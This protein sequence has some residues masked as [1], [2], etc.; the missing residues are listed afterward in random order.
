VKAH[1]QIRVQVGVNQHGR[2]QIR[3]VIAVGVERATAVVCSELVVQ[4]HLRRPQNRAYVTV[5]AHPQV[6]VDVRVDEHRS[7]QVNEISILGG[8]IPSGPSSVH[9]RSRLSPNDGR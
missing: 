9:V 5:K 3:K 4:V 1:P 2:Q 7:Q 8:K 6:S